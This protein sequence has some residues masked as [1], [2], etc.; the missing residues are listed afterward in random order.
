MKKTLT[1]LVFGLGLPCT[2]FAGD[3]EF[4]WSEALRI[5]GSPKNA[6]VFVSNDNKYHR[7]S[8]VNSVKELTEEDVTDNFLN[9][10]ERCDQTDNDLCLDAARYYPDINKLMVNLNLFLP[11][12]TSREKAGSRQLYEH[13]HE[14]AERQ[15]FTYLIKLNPRAAK[16][17]GSKK[18]QEINELPYAQDNVVIGLTMSY[19]KHRYIGYAAMNPQNKVYEWFENNDHATPFELYEYGCAF[20]GIG[21]KKSLESGK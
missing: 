17:V 9:V 12:G 3:Y 10:M 18:Y 2:V 14:I 11:E 7:V 4:T 5:C 19:D 21:C 8:C 13:L 15:M 20:K 1:L 16:L 6:G